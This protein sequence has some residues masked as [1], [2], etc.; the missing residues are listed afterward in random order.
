MFEVVEVELADLEREG[1]QGVGGFEPAAREDEDR[2][3]T[4]GQGA[5]LPELEKRGQGD[6]D[7][8]WQKS[9]SVA[10]RAF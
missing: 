9:P 4:G 1:I 8:G 7:S 3:S 10:A 5:Y 6:G 2:G